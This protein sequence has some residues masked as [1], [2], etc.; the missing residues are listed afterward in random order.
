[1]STPYRW[2]QAEL[3][4]AYDA[5]AEQVHPWYRELQDAI[6][7]RIEPLLR[8]GGCV[9]DLGAGSGR[10][11]ERAL[12]R[13]PGATA[14]LIDQSLPALDVARRRLERFAGRAQFVTARLQDAW[15]EMLPTQPAAIVSMSAIHHLEPGE[16]AACYRQACE[17]LVPGGLFLNGD[18][19]RDPDDA[20]YAAQCRNW[21]AH[22]QRLIDE[23]RV[24]PPMA[25]ALRGWIERNVKQFGGPRSSGDDCHE[26]AAAQLGHLQRAGFHQVQTGWSRELWT[27]L[28]GAKSADA[29]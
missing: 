19:V 22:M 4:A 13:F 26:T 20:A 6:L 16:K 7:S 9:V 2:N 24:R 17:S 23:A 5:D 18:E 21:G 3:A 28:E 11:M 8:R 29:R 12:E 1:M 27:V 14:V 10:L 15:C 25:D